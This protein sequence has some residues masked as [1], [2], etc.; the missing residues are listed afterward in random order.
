MD[1]V[2]VHW[3]HFASGDWATIDNH[4]VLAGTYFQLPGRSNCH[5]CHP[6]FDG[7]GLRHG[8]AIGRRHKVAGLMTNLPM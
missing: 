7:E 3:N 1:R 5:A 8:G 2:F 4:V 6:H